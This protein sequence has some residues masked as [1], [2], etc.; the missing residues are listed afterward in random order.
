MDEHLNWHNNVTTE[1]HLLLL[2]LHNIVA[3][4]YLPVH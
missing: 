2:L 1:T 4:C 3:V